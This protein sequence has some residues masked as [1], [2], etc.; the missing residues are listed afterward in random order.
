M[1]LEPIM[2]NELITNYVSAFKTA[3]PQKDIKVRSFKGGYRVIIDGDAGDKT[4][5]ATD[6]GFAISA[7]RSKGRPAT[8]LGRFPIASMARITA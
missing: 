8:K 6:M 4:L 5:D 3:Y 7:F 1:Q 2:T